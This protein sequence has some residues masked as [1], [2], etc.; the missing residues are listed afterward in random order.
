MQRKQDIT[1]IV[2]IIQ[3]DLLTMS[4][5]CEATIHNVG[6]GVMDRLL[7]TRLYNS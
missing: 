2:M 3:A 1:I 6:S 5:L 7:A 4:P